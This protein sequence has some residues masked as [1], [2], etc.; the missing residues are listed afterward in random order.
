MTN[1]AAG[2]SRLYAHALVMWFV[3][4]FALH[5]IWKL[6]QHALWL[7]LY[8]YAHSPPGAE[9]HSVLVTDIPGIRYGGVHAPCSLAS[10][11]F[12]LDTHKLMHQICAPFR[13]SIQHVNSK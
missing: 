12:T 13:V 9:S 3:T 10:A 6:T 5:R 7:R 2:S 8:H 4:A 1:I 11:L